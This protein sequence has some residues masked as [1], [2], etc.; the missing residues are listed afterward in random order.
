MPL[1][2]CQEKSSLLIKL[3][4]VEDDD[5]FYD[6]D[7]GDYTVRGGGPT[8]FPPAVVKKSISILSTFPHFSFCHQTDEIVIQIS[9]GN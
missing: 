8:R 7:G 4:L 6:D 2:G 5:D 9:V 1:D 3:L